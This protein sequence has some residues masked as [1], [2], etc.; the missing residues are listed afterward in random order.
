VNTGFFFA[1]IAI[2]PMFPAFI[3]GAANLPG[4]APSVGIARIGVISIGAYFVGPTIVGVLSDQITLTYAMLYP[5]MALILS[6]YLARAL[7]GL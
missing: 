7:R 4:I 2:G 1:G 5:V 6:G 3:L